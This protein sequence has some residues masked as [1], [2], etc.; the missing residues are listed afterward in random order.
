MQNGTELTWQARVIG[1]RKS[2]LTLKEI[3]ARIGLSIPAV[4]DLSE[5]RRR[6]PTGDAAIKLDQLYRKRRRRILA[7]TESTQPAE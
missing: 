6:Q 1:L 3:G 2:G 5:G 7:A 4:W